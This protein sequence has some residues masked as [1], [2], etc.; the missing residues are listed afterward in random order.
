MRGARDTYGIEVRQRH[1]RLA[2]LLVG[3]CLAACKKAD[4][5]ERHFY[6]AQIQP[7]FNSFC[8]G[9]TSP[10][11]RIDPASGSALGNLD[12]SSFEAVSKRRDVLRT[13]GSYPQ[14]LLL[15]KA[16]P[17]EEVQ[18]P[19]Q[20]RF[21][22]SEIRHAGGKTLSTRSDAYAQLKRWLDSGAT[23]DGLPAPASN[24][25]GEGGCNT[26]LPPD[27]APAAALRSSEAYRTFVRNVQPLLATSCAFSTCH[28][29]PQSDFYLTCGSSDEQLDHNFLRA[30]SF[31]ATAPDSVEQSELLLRPL[32]PRAGG[33]SH[34]GGVFFGS[35][36]D[37]QWKALRDW[38]STLQADMPVA[39]T[40]G[41]GETF[42]ADN[43]MPVLIRRGCAVEACHSPNGFNDFRLRPGAQGFL[44][45]YAIHRNYELA[46]N[47][48]MSLDTPDVRQSR[49]VKKNI[50]GD[51]GGIAHRGGPLLESPDGTGSA[52]CATP[53]D[54][55]TASALCV[56]TEWHRIE[57]AARGAD[58]SPLAVGDRV[59][60]VFVSRPP[61]GDSLLEFATFRGGADL[62][63]ADAV[64]GATG[65]IEAVE[66]VRSAL[67]ACSA[68]GSGAGGDL[69][70]RGPEWTYDGASVVFAARKGEAGGLDVWRLDAATGACTA[71][72]TDNGRVVGA[73]KVHNFDP[74]FSP[75]GHLIFAS[76]RAGTLTLKRLLPNA[77]LYRLA[78]SLDLGTLERMT[79]LSN[80]ELSPAFMQNGQLSFTAEKASEDFYQLSGRRL[81]WDLSDFHPL[82]AQRAQ[83]DDT[84][85]NTFPSVGYEQATEIREGLDRNFLV[86]LSDRDAKGAGGAL[87]TFNRSVGP[88]EEDR[89]EVTFLK[90][91]LLVD[92]DV[93]GRVGTRGIYRSPSSLPNNEVLA[94]YASSVVNPA[95]DIPRYDLVAVDA[96]T[97]ARRVLVGGGN[98][99]LV[100]GVLGFKRSAR[101]LYRNTPQL[102]FGGHVETGG[103]SVLHFPDLPMLATLLGANLR[104]GRNL[105]T[106][107]KATAL[108]VWQ[109]L[110]PTSAAVDTSKVLGPERVYTDRK[111]L[112][113]APLES[114]K[115]VRVAV[116]A[117]TPLIL[118]LIDGAGQAVFT[119]REEHQV[120]AGEVIT[121]GVP[122]KLFN[123]V[124][125]G[126]HGSVSGKDIDIAVTPDALTGA[127]VSLSRERP[128]KALQ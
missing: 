56:V 74:V 110:P 43:V 29:S 35:R 67:T 100:E 75:Q 22:A 42:F 31:V 71:I 103:E 122:R 54:P 63:I 107:D 21:F 94:S 3:L 24:K 96:R 88:F 33:V 112:G 37:E 95:T 59:P 93:T 106:F 123:G 98:A 118:E 128:P 73:V 111:L 66:N 120:G 58:V 90:S 15:L 27:E 69:D 39:A 23:R 85:G 50:F 70:V 79:V 83:S 48:F 41:P 115:S 82:L 17:E 18:I 102:V 30:A 116:P 91:L 6:E 55:A 127:S 105:E 13:Y 72:T 11:H 65:R 16:L 89:T 51:E 92:R 28:S 25:V 87:A 117:A 114:D 1:G 60:L 49:I 44:S 124:C 78:P 32:D 121:P 99:S 57:R 68:L 26:A 86:I 2:A 12:L 19:Y 77:D 36:D 80:S 4:V 8:V 14:P 40:R 53:F 97:G 62:K 109:P 119:M 47:E 5:P 84:F 38:A 126:C 52:N 7:V 81:N 9:N 46:L 104:R 34:T 61:N 101:A 64:V 76:T 108:R 113:S 10:C 20:R 45:S 125:G